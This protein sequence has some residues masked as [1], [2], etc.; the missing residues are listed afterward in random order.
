MRSER[1]Q[2]LKSVMYED[3]RRAYQYQFKIKQFL[4]GYY[5][6]LGYHYLVWYRLN[7]HFAGTSA[8]GAWCKFRVFKAGRKAGIW[9]GCDD[10]GSGFT[11]TTIVG[12][13]FMR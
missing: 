10:I 11:I 8:L 7:R 5:L 2:A 13:S 4:K 6:D 1:F 9:L 12:F 3:Y